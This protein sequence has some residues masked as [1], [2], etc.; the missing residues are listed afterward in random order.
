MYELLKYAFLHVDI[1]GPRVQDGHFDLIDPT[2]DIILPILWDMLVEPGW[3]VS[4]HIW[5]IS[6]PPPPNPF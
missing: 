4:M 3:S 5:P 2:G 6:E 1:I